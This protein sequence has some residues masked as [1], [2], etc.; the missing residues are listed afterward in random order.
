MPTLGALIYLVLLTLTAYLVKLVF[1]IKVQHQALSYIPALLLLLSYTQLGYYIFVNKTNGIAFS[2]IVGVIASLSIIRCYQLV[3]PNIQ[4][5]V[6]IT[7]FTISYPFIGF[8]SI[9]A[10]VLII[11]MA[12]RE[13]NS[14][15]KQLISFIT[16]LIIIPLAY[17]HAV[18]THQNISLIYT[19]GLPPFSLKDREIIWYIPLLLVIFCLIIL[20]LKIK[21]ENSKAAPILSSSLLLATVIYVFSA[22]F[23][24]ANFRTEIEMSEAVFNHQWKEVIK[25]SDAA[26]LEPS[27]IMVVLTNLAYHKLGIAGDKMFTY[28]HGDRIAK[29]PREVHTIHVIGI[30][31]YF[32]YGKLNYANRWS[33][34][35]MVE[36]GL[37][38]ENLQYM[39]QIAILNGEYALA[40]K[41]INTLQTTL[42]Y[43]DWAKQ[44][45]RY[46]NN[47]TL[48]SKNKEYQQIKQ[49]REFKNNLGTDQSSFENY[50]LYSMA[51]LNDGTPEM[52]EVSLQSC[53]ILKDLTSFL[54]RFNYYARNNEHLGTHYQEAA[55]LYDLVEKNVAINTAHFDKNILERFEHFKRLSNQ[56]MQQSLEEKDAVFRQQ[57]GDTYWYYYFFVNKLVLERKTKETYDR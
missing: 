24:D 30:P 57:F 27:R 18:Y 42:C 52:L 37:N 48:I 8:Y 31:A 35:H 12:I 25:L 41:Y 9:L 26:Q 49:L 2:H 19:V 28:I 46:I 47:S 29:S 15:P 7:F 5:P 44:H 14:T 55:I 20:S 34:E 50:L 11:I 22:S 13:K 53:L 4:I 21:F 56:T 33:V 17:Y 45:Q 1:Q 16:A 32:Y 54:L 23:N 36:Y 38:Y 51:A 39:T 43:K 6:G 10:L 3:K 40:Q